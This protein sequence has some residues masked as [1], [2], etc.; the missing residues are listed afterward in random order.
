MLPVFCL[1]HHLS[2]EEIIINSA[3]C[4]IGLPSFTLFFKA[5]SYKL[6]S[7]F[8]GV[9]HS[10]K[11]CFGFHV[12]ESVF[13]QLIQTQDTSNNSRWQSDIHG[14]HSVSQP[15]GSRWKYSNKVPEMLFP[16]RTSWRH[17][18]GQT[19]TPSDP[20]AVCSGTVYAAKD[21]SLLSEIS[22]FMNS[23]ELNQ[24]VAWIHPEGWRANPK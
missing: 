9:F 22:V 3:V 4:Q 21:F 13:T 7:V 11:Y 2:E 6:C 20:S 17:P 1:D 19:W 10:L 23:K 8:P 18:V 24:K 15:R 12:T 16:L 14:S 5:V